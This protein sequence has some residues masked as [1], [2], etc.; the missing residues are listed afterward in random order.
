MEKEVFVEEGRG[1]RPARL[2]W[3]AVSKARESEGG[4]GE[5]NWRF[6]EAVLLYVRFWVRE[7]KRAEVRSKKE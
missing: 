5:Q 6:G 4:G 2:K 7:R 3:R 1:G